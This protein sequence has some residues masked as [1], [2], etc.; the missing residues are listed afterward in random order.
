[1]PSVTTR[2]PPPLH[3][4]FLQEC[5]R[6]DISPSDFIRKAVEAMMDHIDTAAVAPGSV[7]P[8]DPEVFHMDK[9]GAIHHAKT[10]QAPVVRA[11]GIR[12]FAATDGTPL[13]PA[14]PKVEPD[15]KAKK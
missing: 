15:K 14:A 5:E 10:A 12:G 6:R 3:E 1:M 13:M 11:R 4:R 7:V 2:F 9:D 8:V